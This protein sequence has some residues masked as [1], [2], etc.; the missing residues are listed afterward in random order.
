METQPAPRLDEVIDALKCIG[1]LEVWL[2]G[3]HA[4]GNAE[5][6]SDIDLL[7][8]GPKSV[9]DELRATKPW[10]YD[11]FVNITGDDKFYSPWREASGS[12]LSWK[13]KRVEEDQAT[14]AAM[15]PN[16]W[17]PEL[18]SGFGRSSAIRV[19]PAES[20][21]STASVLLDEGRP[22]R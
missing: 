1:A 10:P 19:F 18:S 4:N 7:V 2:F 3:S 5:P 20:G 17:N 11:I 14:Y 12:F 9:L 22:R 6:S 8:V 16:K 15:K 13:W 21:R